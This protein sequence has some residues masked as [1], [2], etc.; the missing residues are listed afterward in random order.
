MSPYRSSRGGVQLKIKGGGFRKVFYSV[1][2]HHDPQMDQ[3]MRYMI[4]QVLFLME[5]KF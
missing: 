1:I 2:Y 5:L 3:Q 4:V